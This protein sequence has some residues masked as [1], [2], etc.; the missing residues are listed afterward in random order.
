MTTYQAYEVGEGYGI[1]S[2]RLAQRAMPA[3]AAQ[4]VLLKIKAVS[5]NYRDLL[6]VGGQGR[7]KP[8]VGRIPVS[9]A[10]GEVVGRG[11]AVS[12]LQIGDR[13][14]GLFLPDWVE[15]KL[16][17]EK[18]SRSL[19]GA[20]SDGMLAQYVAIAEQE[21]IAVP[22]PLSDEEAA[23]LPC[24]GLT[25]W[26]ALIEEG[27]AQ[28]GERVLIQGTGGVSLFALQFALVAGLEVFLLSG[29]EEKLAR[30]RQLG[31]DHLINYRQQPDWEEEVLRRTDGE[32]VDHV[33]EVVGGTN[34]AKSTVAVRTGGSIYAI[35]FL[36]SHL[37]EVNIQQLMGKQIRLQGIEV[38]SRAMFS[39]M[40]QAIALH[41]IRPVIDEVFPFGQAQSALRRQQDGKQFG[42]VCIRVCEE[43]L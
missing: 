38:G 5:L 16:S 36:Q 24:A 35:G 6:V 40:N 4:Q 32:G 20:A 37:S 27:R 22:T 29:S 43:C 9:D 23:C 2:L 7:W 28:A 15:G 41:G 11:S 25:A 12:Q 18:Q 13:V 21:V 17:P 42:K 34:L 10:V 30:A 39:R 1:E 8:P 3:L 33:V 31:V 26:H 19:G 14:A